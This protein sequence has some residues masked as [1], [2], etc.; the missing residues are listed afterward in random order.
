MERTDRRLHSGL[1]QQI[2][3][4]T[5]I[6]QVEL[7]SELTLGS[8]NSMKKMESRIENLQEDLQIHAGEIE[9]RTLQRLERSNRRIKSL[10]KKMEQV[11]ES[12]Q[13]KWRHLMG[14]VTEKTITDGRIQALFDRHNHLV[15]QFEN[16]LS[17]MQ[18]IIDEQKIQLMNA[19][20][21][22]SR[23]RREIERLKRL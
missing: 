1:F 15:H 19:R 12:F 11:V 5:E 16:R 3:R 18:R 21:H 8:L 10:E 14:K 6:D 13:S 17:Q 2:D 4:E 23:A 9:K 7:S 20:D 22:L